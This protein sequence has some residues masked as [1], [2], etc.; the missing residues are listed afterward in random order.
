[1]KKN[2]RL[3][4]FAKINMNL[5]I[6]SRRSDGYHEISSIMQD[7]DIYDEIDISVK[8]F[9]IDKTNTKAHK[10]GELLSKETCFINNQNIKFILNIKDSKYPEFLNV[11]IKDNLITKSAIRFFDIFGLDEK[12]TVQIDISKKLPL[13]GGIGGGSADGSAILLGLNKIFGNPF[14]LNELMELGTNIGADFPFSVMMNAFKNRKEL[15]NLKGI[16]EA[17]IAA[18]VSGIGDNINPIESKPYYIILCDPGINIST[19]E[20]Y[21]GIDKMKIQKKDYEIFQNDMENYTLKEYDKVRNLKEVMTRSL[22]ADAVLMSGSGSIIAGYYKSAVAG[23]KDFKKLEQIKDKDI[24]IWF[25]TTG[26][27]DC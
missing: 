9:I 25:T 1:M 14:T 20:V 16:E 3:K 26:G 2:I 10:E 18:K 15:K 27:P 7:L 22:N 8:D 21:D 4:A 6:L 12:F 24:D 19:K 5:R 11:D 17:S 13:G 23:A